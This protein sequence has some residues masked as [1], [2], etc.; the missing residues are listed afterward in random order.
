MPACHA[1]HVGS[2]PTR[3]VALYVQIVHLLI[4]NMQSAFDNI[5]STYDYETCKEIV[6]HGCQSGVCT[7]HIYYGDT[8]KFFDTHEDEIV[9]YVT[10]A[11]EIDTLVAIFR[12]AEASLKHYKNYLVWTFIE[13]VASYVVDEYEEQE[14]KDDETIGSYQDDEPIKLYAHYTDDE[15]KVLKANGFNPVRSMSMSR[16][17]NI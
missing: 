10:D 6:D 4:I 7:E 17:A 14:R 8:I 9:E 13:L 5:K 11:F 16:Y 3:I 15:I 12:Q 2:I 1:G